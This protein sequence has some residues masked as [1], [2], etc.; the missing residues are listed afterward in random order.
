MTQKN[1]VDGSQT[2]QKLV[3][4]TISGVILAGGEGKRVEEKKGCIQYCY[5]A[6]S[7]SKTPTHARNVSVSLES[8][9]LPMPCKYLDRT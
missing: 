2:R 8:N 4:R 7:N 5:G 9:C 1:S 3:F 6:V